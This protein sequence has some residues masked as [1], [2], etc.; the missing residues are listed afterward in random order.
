MLKTQH[1]KALTIV[2]TWAV[3]KAATSLLLVKVAAKAPPVTA[4]VP[5]IEAAPVIT[6]AAATALGLKLTR[7]AATSGPENT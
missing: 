4:T 7:V 6:H 5:V 2:T 1:G 3:S